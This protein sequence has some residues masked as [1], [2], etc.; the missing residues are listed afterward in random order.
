MIKARGNGPGGRDTIILGLSHGNLDRLRAGEPIKFDGTPYG[1][2]GDVLIF[3]G[4]TEISM[5]RKLGMGTDPD[6]RIHAE[7]EPT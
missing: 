7:D 6:I 4:E 2:A 1:F 3:A 5:A